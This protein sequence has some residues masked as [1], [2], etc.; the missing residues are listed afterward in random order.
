MI[1][2]DEKSNQ[3]NTDEIRDYFD[4]SGMNVVFNDISTDIIRRTKLLGK[5]LS[6]RAGR[7]VIDNIISRIKT[8]ESIVKKLIRKNREVTVQNALTTLHDIIGIRVVCPF[9]DDVF[10]LAE[11]I[12]KNI[13]YEVVN[14]KDFVSKPKS[15]GYR[16]IHII[17]A[18]NDSSGKQLFA[19]IQIRSVAMNYW[20]ILEHLLCYKSEDDRVRA[21]HEQLKEYAE[22]IAAIDRKFYK[23]RCKIEKL[24]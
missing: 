7:P 18:C 10:L 1:S 15:S 17:L 9:Q 21:L 2:T 8:P 23:L 11:E 24:K 12:R 22:E 16:S 14:V 5:R 6:D 13:G 19:E 20:A 3:Q 4:S